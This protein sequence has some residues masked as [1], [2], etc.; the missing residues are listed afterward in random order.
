M[1][2]E[3]RINNIKEGLY[4]TKDE[5]WKLISK[6]DNLYAVSTLGRVMSM[7]KG[8]I[9][10]TTITNKG[11]ELLVTHIN[12]K[13]KGYSVH[14]LVAEAFIPNP[15]NYP[16]VNHKDENPLNNKVENLE[17]CTF[18]YNNRYNNINIKSGLKRRGRSPYNKNTTSDKYKDKEVLMISKDGDIIKV[19][20]TLGFATT[21]ICDLYNKK[22]ITT[23]NRIK[24]VLVEKRKSYLGYIWQ[25]RNK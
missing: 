4:D 19:F 23:Y 18:S 1:E 11:Y 9:M 22:R 3:S 20:P 12:G 6:T 13:Q 8:N 10:K 21:Y 24:E 14:R 17:W 5:K 7:K 25:W 2:V 15:N 16:I